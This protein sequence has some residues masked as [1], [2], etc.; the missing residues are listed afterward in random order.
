MVTKRII[1]GVLCL[2]I[3]TAPS[4]YSMSTVK[5]C[6]AFTHPIGQ[7]AAKIGSLS[8]NALS[9]SLTHPKT[10]T[11][12]LLGTGASAGFIVTL[13]K[14][15]SLLTKTLSKEHSW[16]SS[17]LRKLGAR[18][19]DSEQDQF[20][21]PLLKAIRYHDFDEADMYTKSGVK[22][23]AIEGQ[24]THLCNA[25]VTAVKKPT[26]ELAQD[27]LD[28]IETLKDAG[29]NLEHNQNMTQ[30]LIDTFIH[31]TDPE[32]ARN[33]YDY[34][35]ELAQSM[36]ALKAK[37]T[38]IPPAAKVQ[39]NAAD[40]DT[41]FKHFERLTNKDADPTS[42][43]FKQ[44]LQE[45][46]IIVSR[47]LFR[48]STEQ[49]SERSFTIINRAI[50]QKRDAVIKLMMQ[51]GLDICNALLHRAITFKKD[52]VFKLM[53]EA[54]FDINTIDYYGDTPLHHFMSQLDKR[55]DTTMIEYLCSKKDH[56]KL[57]T[58]NKLGKT[59]MHIA[60]AKGYIR[61]IQLLL[62][63]GADINFPDLKGKTPL[64][65]AVEHGNDDTVQFLLDKGADANAQDSAGK[66]ALMH[67]P[68]IDLKEDKNA[69]ELFP[70]L[71][72]ILQRLSTCANVKLADHQGK[73][74]LHHLAGTTFMNDTI[75]IADQI[76]EIIGNPELQS[77][78]PF[79][80][81]LIP[82]AQ[83]IKRTFFNSADKA[84]IDAHDNAGNT[85]LLIACR[86]GNVWIA[87]KLLKNQANVNAQDTN[88]QTP[89]MAAL[90]APLQL[91][92]NIVKKLLEY[93]PDLALTDQQHHD[94]F[95]YSLP[96]VDRTT[97][98]R[99]QDSFFHKLL[100]QHQAQVTAH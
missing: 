14:K 43:E 44:T 37:L 84:F 93:K 67:I 52:D 32:I 75:V 58:P 81:K 68:K 7:L 91:R 50:A 41:L 65:E 60:A 23:P 59:P 64:M 49:E 55:M 62:E 73:T 15:N 16:L 5:K 97:G 21:E 94:A 85:P 11:A 12:L 79:I 34:Y 25:F 63:A 22:I 71:L 2:L 54:G 48:A 20:I 39:M 36:V 86:A 78:L 74:I 92:E 76:K 100:I 66:T 6:L 61:V 26:K 40:M 98:E 56:L 1:R 53:V 27:A 10:M 38:V 77:L 45:A 89:L 8:K 80:T 57:N 88:Q 42:D 70:S 82:P 29:V 72:N 33:Q 83:E 31:L 19:P 69:E 51:A 47:G 17:L 3:I 13:V 46:Q 95:Y 24:D 18:V 90:H 96:V 87:E 9:F 28:L 30:I 99:A 35:F 4:V